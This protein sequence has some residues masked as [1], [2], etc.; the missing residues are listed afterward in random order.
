MAAQL[1]HLGS[2]FDRK[3]GD[4]AYLVKIYYGVATVRAERDNGTLGPEKKYSVDEFERR[5]KKLGPRR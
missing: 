5:F 1:K 4:L 3:T 2:Y